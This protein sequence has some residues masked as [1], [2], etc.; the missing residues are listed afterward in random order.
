MSVEYEGV[1]R[2]CGS[3]FAWKSEDVVVVRRRRMW[4]MKSKRSASMTSKTARLC[5]ARESHSNPF[6]S[7]RDNRLKRNPLVNK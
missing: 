6:R 2:V 5:V 7:G 4:S 1:M 3:E